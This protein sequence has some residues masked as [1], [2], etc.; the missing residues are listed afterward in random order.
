M[1]AS[2]LHPGISSS[3]RFDGRYDLI[4]Y[5]GGGAFGE[6]WEAQDSTTGRRVALK[7]IDPSRTSADDAWREA[8][9][10]TSL[11]SPNGP[12]TAF[13]VGVHGA[14]MSTL[15]V[16]Y[17]DMVLLDGSVQAR[18]SGHGVDE[19]MAARWIQRVARGLH[20]CHE[21]GLL[22]RDVKPDNILLSRQGD[23]LLGDF[24]AAA[25]MAADAT[26][27][28]HGDAQVRA[29]EV[30]GGRCTVQSDVYS[31]GVSLYFLVAGRYPHRLSDF[32]GDAGAFVTAVKAGLPDVRDAAPHL[33]LG[34]TRIIRAATAMDLSQRYPS[35]AALDL[36]LAGLA[37]LRR[38]IREVTPCA[39]AERC[40][41]ASPSPRQ[42]LLPVHV[43]TTPAVRGGI[44]IDTRH[45]GGQ[46]IREHCAVVKRRDEAARLRRVFRSLQ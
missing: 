25:I 44:Q 17:I 45:R 40:W 15:G 14:A 26:A 3:L 24:G 22:H 12:N 31:L 6:V 43:C 23:A 37:P 39:G 34:L 11:A 30:F 8:T 2:R 21:R 33:S 46:R 28:E 20:L 19:A 5:L 4:A 16:P 36:A 35:A 42:A 9:L 13:L 38:V 32:R 10:L 41:D 27:A 7:L 1:P 18:A 29:P